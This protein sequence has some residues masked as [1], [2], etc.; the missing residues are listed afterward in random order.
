MAAV[1]GGTSILLHEL[2]GKA[3]VGSDPCFVI[4]SCS[5]LAVSTI[6][7]LMVVRRIQCNR[8]CGVLSCAWHTCSVN[9]SNYQYYPC[10]GIQELDNL[11]G[12][13]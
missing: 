9:G 5:I 11:I 1:M 12:N 8:V 7:M 3:E 2:W 13:S 4:P 10:S 6:E